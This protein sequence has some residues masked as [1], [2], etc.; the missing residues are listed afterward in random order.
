MLVRKRT[1]K[2]I[3]KLTQ[4]ALKQ[5][6]HANNWVSIASVVDAIKRLDPE[7]DIVP[8][9]FSSLEEAVLAIAGGW[10]EFKD[11]KIKLGKVIA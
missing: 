4:E 5:V 7:L 10:V 3:I 8:Y 9:G 11:N 6:S 2:T 1:F